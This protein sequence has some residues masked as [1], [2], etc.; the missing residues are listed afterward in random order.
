MPRDIPEIIWV[1]LISRS[2]GVFLWENRIPR[3]IAP[4]AAV[5]IN[6]GNWFA[7]HRL[8]AAPPRARRNDFA[9][10]PSIR[11]CG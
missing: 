2:G 11:V 7:C 6:Y 4:F 3:T 1:S 5:E 10:A 9:K 8:T